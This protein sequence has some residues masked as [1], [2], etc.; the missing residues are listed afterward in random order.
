MT[1]PDTIDCIAPA[2]RLGRVTG[3]MRPPPSAPA[4]PGWLRKAPDPDARAATRRGRLMASFA[5]RCGV[6]EASRAP[7]RAEVARASRPHGIDL[8]RIGWCD[9][10]GVL[11]GKSLV[12]GARRRRAAQRRRHGQHDPAEGHL[13]PHRLPR[14]RARRRRRAARLRLREQP[15]CCCLDPTSFR[16]LPWAPATGWLR[17]RPGSRTA[18]RCRSTRGASCSRRSRGSSAPASACSCGLEVEFH[19]YR[20]HRADDDPSLDPAAR[21][22][23][24]RAAVDDDDPSGLQPARRRLGRHGRRAAAHRPAHRAGARPAAALARD[25][26]RPEPGRGGVRADRCA[27]RGRPMVLF[28]NGVRQALRRAGYHASF[29]CRPPFPERDGERM[30]PAP[31]AGRPGDRRAT[32]S[33]RDGRRPAATPRRCRAHACPT[34]ARTTLPAC[35]RTA[36]RWRRSAR[37]R[38]TAYGRFRPNAMAPQA[39]DL[40]PRQPR[41]DAARARRRGDAGDPDRE[42]HRR[43]DGQ[44]VP[45]RRGADPRRARRHRARLVAPG[46][47]RRPRTPA[48][49]RCCRR[50]SAKA[51]TRSPA[52]AELVRAFGRRRRR[53]V[54]ARQARR[55][56][57][58]TTRPTTTGPWQARE[59]FSRF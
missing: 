56:A 18:R 20:L 41:R 44:P 49:A 22:V 40:G 1:G 52:D 15:A 31:V 59:Y 27:D 28:R 55:A 38:S 48:A 45:V 13:R 12:A 21:R 35:S 6:D 5:A 46:R 23:A 32:R 54:R 34:S 37:R 25:R 57:R 50:A 51:S 11:R 10:H 33:A 4:R 19:I 24:G 9:L 7:L 47:R 39:V 14:L 36:A 58:A 53:L 26:A 43:A 17:P 29:V 3:P 42:P 16:V 8:V 2:D 30:A